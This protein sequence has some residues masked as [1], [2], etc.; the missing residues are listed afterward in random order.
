MW[1]SISFP[2]VSVAHCVFRRVQQH[3]LSH[4]YFTKPQE[5]FHPCP[6]PDI[7]SAHFECGVQKD[8]HRQPQLPNIEYWHDQRL[9]RERSKPSNAG[10]WQISESRPRDLCWLL[11]YWVDLP[12]PIELCE[13][14]PLL[15]ADEN[16]LHDEYAVPNGF[17]ETRLEASVVHASS[18]L[19]R[20]GTDCLS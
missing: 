1:L 8:Y 14:I 20:N 4:E 19:P 5:L 7:G 6:S 17:P 13:R 12:W 18:I 11:H 2:G 10:V 9:D 16:A 15:A 3:H